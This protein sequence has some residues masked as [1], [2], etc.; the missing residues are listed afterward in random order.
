MWGLIR[1]LNNN[2]NNNW[3]YHLIGEKLADRRE[4]K[5]EKMTNQRKLY[6]IFLT[7]QVGWSKA[8]DMI[9]DPVIC[10]EIYRSENLQSRLKR[11]GSYFAKRAKL[12]DKLND[13]ALKQELYAEAIQHE[14]ET[15]KNDYKRNSNQIKNQDFAL[16]DH[17]L[18]NVKYVVNYMN[19]IENTEQ[20]TK[21]LL[22][23]ADICD[24]A[25]IS[26]L[27]PTIRIEG[28]MIQPTNETREFGREIRRDVDI[29][30]NERS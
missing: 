30:V 28:R 18:S 16:A 1:R 22:S 23:A 25:P 21:F 14:I 6:K 17:I 2:N 3:F 29:I 7:E 15:I 12:I 19:K 8:L 5:I 10:E 24:H 11:Y 20:R 9:T 13:K 26:V 4:K 27:V